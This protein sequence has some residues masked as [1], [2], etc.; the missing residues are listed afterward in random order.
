MRDHAFLSQ[1][2]TPYLQA[3]LPDRDSLTTQ[4]RIT[5]RQ[6]LRER[7]APFKRPAKR[8]RSKQRQT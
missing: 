5:A 7:R 6:I 1:L 8:K 4:E 2:P 3:I